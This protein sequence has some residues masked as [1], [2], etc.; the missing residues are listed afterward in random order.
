MKKNFEN[1]GMKIEKFNA[2]NIVTASGAT[3]SNPEILK[4]QLE[5]E[6]YAVSIK[7]LLDITL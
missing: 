4:S 6:G 7:S 2:E 5:S 1:P 3:T